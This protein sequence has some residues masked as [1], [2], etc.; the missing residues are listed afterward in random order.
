M[1]SPQ[2][3][4]YATTE[5]ANTDVVAPGTLY[6]PGVTIPAQATRLGVSVRFTVPTGA[7]TLVL[8]HAFVQTAVPAASA[9]DAASWVDT[10]DVILYN[11]TSENTIGIAVGSPILGK[12]RLRVLTSFI[13]GGGT[14][15]LLPSWACDSANPIPL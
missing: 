8:V 11:G 9:G 12:V 7:V 10:G 6:T 2:T 3:L 15:R 5:S 14:L 4:P 13:N 1:S